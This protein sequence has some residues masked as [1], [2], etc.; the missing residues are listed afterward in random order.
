MRARDRVQQ[1]MMHGC[2]HVPHG[3][4]V[5][6]FG[7]EDGVVCVQFP[8]ASLKGKGLA[9]SEHRSRAW[10]ALKVGHEAVRREIENKMPGHGARAIVLHQSQPKTYAQSAKKH[11]N[12]SLF[13]TTNQ[14]LR[15]THTPRGHA[16][17][18]SSCGVSSYQTCRLPRMPALLKYSYE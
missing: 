12:K 10:G 4:P 11:T 16:H 7:V 14:R 6:A 9:W 1:A 13:H 2:V 3:A 5:D 15:L 18:F 17:S 8:I